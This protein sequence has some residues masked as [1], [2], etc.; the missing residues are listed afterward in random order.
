MP[1]PPKPNSEMIVRSAEE[2]EAFKA[3]M[4]REFSHV[5]SETVGWEISRIV[6]SVKARLQTPSLQDEL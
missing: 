3:K 5:P 1:P 4:R 2:V 6:L